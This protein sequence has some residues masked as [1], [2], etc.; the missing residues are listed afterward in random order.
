MHSCPISA[1]ARRMNNADIISLSLLK[2]CQYQMLSL[3]HIQ[4]MLK[5]EF[6]VSL[7]DCLKN[8]HFIQTYIVTYCNVVNFCLLRRDSG[9]SAVCLNEELNSFE[10]GSVLF[11]TV[12]VCF[13]YW[14]VNMSFNFWP[15]VYSSME[16]Q[17]FRAWLRTFL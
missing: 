11:F 1:T 10:L 12:F 16:K 5:M 15:L 7:Q 3:I 6:V 13:F 8:L 17:Q 9:L 4:W 2:C 14:F